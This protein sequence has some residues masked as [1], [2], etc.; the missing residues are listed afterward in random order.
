MKAFSQKSIV[1]YLILWFSALAVSAIQPKDFLT[2]IMEVAPM[3]IASFVLWY[4]HNR[5]PLPRFIMI[6]IFLHGVILMI[7]GHYTY[8]H[9]PIGFWIRDSLHLTRNPYDRIG[10]FFQG[11]VPALI[12]QEV[13]R[14]HLQI[15]SIAWRF[16]LVLTVCMAIS[17]TYELIEWAAAVIMGQGA[18]AF[19]GTQGDPW[20]T[21]WDMFTA[22]IGAVLAQIVYWKETSKKI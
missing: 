12:A 1:I 4:S 10:H 8:A 20:D 11:F 15:K 16:F 17:M 22:V 14:R 7:G 21:Q 2:W 6:W 19:L 18:D 13:L 9:V 5:F 3:I